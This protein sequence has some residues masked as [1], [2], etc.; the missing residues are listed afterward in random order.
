MLTNIYDVLRSPKSA[1]AR[2]AEEADLRKSLNVQAIIYFINALTNKY[3]ATTDEP[4]WMVLLTSVIAVPVALVIVYLMAGVT[5]GIAHL[6]GGQ[7][8]WKKQFITLGYSMLPQMLFIPLEVI[9][10]MFGM[11][12]A[13]IIS[14]VVASVWGIVVSVFA[15]STVQKL[16]IGKSCVVLFAPTAIAFIIGVLIAAMVIYMPQ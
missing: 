15:V 14:A 5:H 1:M 8:T 9:F 16:S 12:T 7:G 3:D 13:V 2:I 11:E 10:L 6:M 4:L